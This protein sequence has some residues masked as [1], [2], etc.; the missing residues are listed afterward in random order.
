M[1]PALEREL[2]AMKQGERRPIVLPPVEAY[3]PVLDE[4]LRALPLDA[5]HEQARQVGRK[6]MARSPD[7]SEEMFDVVALQGDRV[8]IDMNH[9][10]TG[11]TLQFDLELLYDSH[12]QSQ[13]PGARVPSRTQVISNSF[14]AASVIAE[15]TPR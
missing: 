8:V 14:P 13:D 10:L 3:G 2:V 6:V 12:G 11:R 7:G 15:R 9:L 4:E 5:I 1:L